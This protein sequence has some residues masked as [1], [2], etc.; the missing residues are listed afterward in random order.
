MTE[1]YQSGW[2]PPVVMVQNIADPLAF[3]GKVEELRDT[4]WDHRKVLISKDILKAREKRKL[5]VQF[6]NSLKETV[7]D[8][9]LEELAVSGRMDG[10]LERLVA[11]EVD[12]YTLAEE[13][14]KEYLKYGEGVGFS[15]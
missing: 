5:A 12:P 1:K 3:A 7:L 13:L 11:K 4:F 6:T 9:I 8:P 2:Q 10:F 14:A 15:G